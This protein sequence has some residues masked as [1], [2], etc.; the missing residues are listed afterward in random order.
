MPRPISYAVFCLKKKN[1]LDLNASF[2]ERLHLFAAATEDERV[3]SLQT[4]H[5]QTQQCILNKQRIDFALACALASTTFADIVDSS[6]GR[7]LCEYLCSH[8]FVMED[9]VCAF[10]D[11]QRFQRYQLRISWTAAH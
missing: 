11:L 4:N 8:Q 1:N 2:A 3:S 5:L 6:C 9:H 7:N 10:Q